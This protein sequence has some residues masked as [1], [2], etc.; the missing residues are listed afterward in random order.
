M[1]QEAPGLCCLLVFLLVLLIK[2]LNFSL[3]DPGH[4][5]PLQF[6]G[7]PCNRITCKASSPPPPLQE[8]P[9]QQDEVLVGQICPGGAAGGWVALGSEQ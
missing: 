2:A 3:V 1:K 6:G 7:C 9:S 4:H 8:A 5:G